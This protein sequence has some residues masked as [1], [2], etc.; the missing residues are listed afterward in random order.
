MLLC[1]VAYL[2]PWTNIWWVLGESEGRCFET[3]CW[4]SIQ[5]RCRTRSSG[6]Q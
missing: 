1:W 2:C 4:W 6:N 3:C 5:E